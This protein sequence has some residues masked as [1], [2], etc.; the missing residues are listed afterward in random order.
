MLTR[1]PNAEEVSAEQLVRSPASCRTKTRARNSA[2]QRAHD[3]SFSMMR[4]QRLQRRRQRLQR[5]QDG[6]HQERLGP[7]AER[8]EDVE[9]VVSEPEEG[10]G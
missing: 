7:G 3:P 4:Q 10:L 2:F 6:R 8:V 1:P 9:C 5:R